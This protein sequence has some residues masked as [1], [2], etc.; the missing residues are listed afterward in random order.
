MKSYLR[1]KVLRSYRWV[2]RDITCYISLSNWVRCPLSYLTVSSIIIIY[3]GLKKNR[4]M[5]FHANISLQ[6]LSSL[7]QS[8]Y[9]AP[10]SLNHCKH[11]WI[12]CTMFCAFFLL[13]TSLP[14]KESRVHRHKFTAIASF[15]MFYSNPFWLERNDGKNVYCSSFGARH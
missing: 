11:F 3:K 12:L 10:I 9:Q 2:L 5:I 6:Y 8:Q 15:C 13:H 1:L 7:F 14:S 4:V